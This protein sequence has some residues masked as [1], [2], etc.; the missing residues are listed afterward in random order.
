MS[1]PKCALITAF[2]SKTKDRFHEYNEDKTLDQR[3]AIVSRMDGMTGVEC[4]FPYETGDAAT[5]VS[6]GGRLIQTRDRR[7]IVREPRGRA[8]VEQLVGR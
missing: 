5:C 8:H 1:Q 3:L 7:S 2:V 4:I 6:R